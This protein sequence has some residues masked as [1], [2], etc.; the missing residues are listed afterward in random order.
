V[1]SIDDKVT[2]GLGPDIDEEAGRF[3][4]ILGWTDVITL[5][6][7]I[8]LLMLLALLLLS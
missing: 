1:Q 3:V 2:R 5:A 4:T 8:T 6:L 7:A